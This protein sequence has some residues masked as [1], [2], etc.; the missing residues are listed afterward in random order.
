MWGGGRNVETNLR[1]PDLGEISL[2]QVC[3]PTA[4]PYLGKW[5]PS[6]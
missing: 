6:P 4:G 5:F 2:S 3:I 1:T